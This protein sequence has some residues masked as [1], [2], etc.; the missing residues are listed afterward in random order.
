[1][2]GQDFWALATLALA[3]ASLAWVGW[4]CLPQVLKLTGLSRFRNGIRA[5]PEGVHLDK[6]PEKHADLGLQLLDLGFAPLGVYWE[7]DD[8]RRTFTEYVFASEKEGC[9]ASL[10]G[11]TREVPRV[12]FITAFA[13]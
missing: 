3:T 13:D 2:F 9:Y 12:S 6:L 8:F 4:I 1:M 5:G 7:S 11:F 10:Y